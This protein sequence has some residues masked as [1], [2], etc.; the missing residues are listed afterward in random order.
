MVLII[1]SANILH[2]NGKMLRQNS[3][4]VLLLCASHFPLCSTNLSS[5]NSSNA[6]N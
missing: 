3:E 1:R 6:V 5:F 4:Y 2:C